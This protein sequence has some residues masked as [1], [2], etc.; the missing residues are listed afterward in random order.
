MHNEYIHRE[1]A[2]MLLLVLL[3]GSIASAQ[4][5]SVE[6]P[7]NDSDHLAKLSDDVLWHLELSDIAEVRTFRYT[8]LPSGDSTN[9][10]ILYAY[11]FIPKNLGRT[12]K[13]P[14]IVLVHGGVHSNHMTGGPANAAN[15]VREMMEQGYV[16]VAPDYRGSTGYGAKYS[17]AIDYGGKEN[18]DVL[19]ARNWMLERYPFLDPARVGIVGWSHGGMIALFNILLHPGAYACAYAGEPVSDLLERRKYIKSMLET[20]T[21]SAGTA[22][23]KD[24]KKYRRRSPVTYAA[25]LEKPLLIHGNTNDETVRIIE[26]QRLIEALKAA[27]RK[28]EYKI[29]DAAPG[30]HHFNR[31]DSKLARESRGE[32]YNFL[33]KHL[34]PLEVGKP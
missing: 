24:D 4:Q 28:F 32:I 26:V 34:R 5:A 21:E 22:A 13:A 15:I 18:D 27:S 30:G 11:S 12:K 6:G 31:I 8:G 25:K 1:K 7:E 29:Y 16:V 10:M 17:K 33:N 3:I 2:S 19:G 20:M 9:P 23:A 14:L